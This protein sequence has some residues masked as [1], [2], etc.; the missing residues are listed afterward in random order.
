MTT[1]GADLNDITIHSPRTRMRGVKAPGAESRPWI[2]TFSTSGLLR[3][4]QIIHV[5]IMEAVHPTKIVRTH[6]STTYFLACFEGAGK[7]LIDGRWRRCASGH[8]CLLPAHVLNGFEAIPRTPWKFCWVCYEQPA[9]QRPISGASS[10]VMTQ[11]DATALH[12]A[13]TGLIHE[14]SNAAE[15][16]MVHH[17]IELIHNYVVRFAQ[18]FEKDNR[19]WLLWKRVADDLRVDWT[20][21]RLTREAGYSKEHLRRLC[22]NQMGRGPMHQVIYLRLQRAAELLVSTDRTIE[23]IADEVGYRNPFVFSNA[24]TK[25]IGWRPSEYR[26]KQAPKR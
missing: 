21:E 12:A 2:A 17:W 14:T 11:F 3:Q 5:G 18:P 16:A 26:K 22:Q 25:W 15:P 19:L 1:A 24:F 20:L 4:H 10:P 9:T 23:A 13:V 8:A 7:V 6:Q